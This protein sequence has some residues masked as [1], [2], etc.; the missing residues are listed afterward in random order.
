V[1]GRS[2]ELAKLQFQVRFLVGS[3]GRVAQ[4][5]GASGF[6]PGGWEFESLRAHDGVNN[7]A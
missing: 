3:C 2:Q 1:K 5:D 7:W 4:S 6:E